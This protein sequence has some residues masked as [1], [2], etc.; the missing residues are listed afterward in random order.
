MSDPALD[1]IG[2]TKY[3]TNGPVSMY[4]AKM[5]AANKV[6]PVSTSNDYKPDVR[7][8]RIGAWSEKKDRN[9]KGR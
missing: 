8:K 2:G 4:D 7:R 1:F 3:Y 9:K 5:L 6:S